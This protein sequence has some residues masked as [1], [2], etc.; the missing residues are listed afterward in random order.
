M[1]RKF[2]ICRASGRSD[3]KFPLQITA[4]SANG[5][6]LIKIIGR[7]SDWTQ[8]NSIEIGQKVDEFIAQGVKDVKVY[9]RTPGGDVFEANEIVNIIKK[10]PGRK[11]GELGAI[12]ASAGTYISSNLDYVKI[13]SNGQYM[14]HKPSAT[15]DGNEDELASKLKFVQNATSD[16]KKAY[17][18]KT[19]LSEEQIEVMW[20]KGDV[21]LS[22][23]EAKD[24]GFV[25]EIISDDEEVTAEFVELM[26]ACGAPV[27][28][29]V[30]QPILSNN[31]SQNLKKMDPILLATLG[32]PADATQ[33]QVNAKVKE[34]KQAQEAAKLQAEAKDK[35]KTAADIKAELDKA[36]Q[37]KRIKPAQRSYYEKQLTADFEGTKAH[38][39]TLEP[40]ILPGAGSRTD[41]T[42]EA[43]AADRKDWKYKDWLD[44]DPEALAKMRTD[45]SPKFEALMNAYYNEK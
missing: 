24:K 17:A 14:I 7:I 16:Y 19:G 39:A 2:I 44:K 15:L 40:L 8:N 26:R 9:L 5:T 27:L 22:A 3:I 37:E 38:L 31:N 32:L 12:C 35:E 25:D 21:W 6:A 45:D 33:E 29:Q 30:K 42:A 43:E 11:E 34:L 36:E 4:I 20:S 23:Q 1:K 13:A 18:K 28:P 10:F 41:N